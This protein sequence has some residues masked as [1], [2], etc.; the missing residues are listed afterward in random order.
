[1]C[2]LG[3]NFGV[4]PIGTKK[5]IIQ[6]FKPFDRVLVRNTHDNKWRPRHF[7]S[8]TTKEEKPDYW[9]V[10][11]YI[12]TS[13]APYQYCI[14]YEGN[15]KYAHTSLDFTPKEDESD[16][17]MAERKAY[18]EATEKIGHCI[19]KLEKQRKLNG[20]EIFAYLAQ[21]GASGEDIQK[22]EYI[23]YRI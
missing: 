21:L 6:G 2:I 20:K 8:Y 22:I 3:E 5:K 10:Y 9:Q 14:P 13:G 19:A 17:L 18:Q 15:E 4:D 12:V 11:P 23:L 1:M 7:A 16:Q